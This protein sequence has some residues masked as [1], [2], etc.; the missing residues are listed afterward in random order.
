LTLWQTVTRTRGDYRW[1]LFLRATAL[2][3]AILIPIAL[4]FPESIPLVWLAVVGV[5]ANGPLSPILP[6]LWDPL[7][8]EAGKHAPALAVTMVALGVYMYM[9]FVNW[10]IYAWVITWKRLAAVRQSRAVRW[11]VDRFGRAPGTTVVFFAVTPMPFWVVR[12]LAL[13]RGYPIGRFMVAT[14]IG[15]FP[16]FFMYAWLGSTLSV[17]TWALVVVIVGGAVVAISSRLLKREPM[18]ADGLVD[19]PGSTEANAPTQ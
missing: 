16:R 7:I 3:G 11:G 15:R 9:E 4:L 14:A 1:D 2:A 10:H 18:L 19:G 12:C 13:L 8:I 6:T 17:P 5:P